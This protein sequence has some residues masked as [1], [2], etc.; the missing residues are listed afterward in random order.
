MRAGEPIY[1]GCMGGKGRTGLFWPY[2]RRRS[3]WLSPWSSLATYYAHA[4]ETKDQHEFVAVSGDAPAAAEDRWSGGGR[5]CVLE[6]E[7]DPSRQWSLKSGG[8][9]TGPF[10]KRLDP[11]QT[12]SAGISQASEHHKAR[13]EEHTGAL[14][15][16]PDPL[17]D[18]ADLPTEVFSKSTL[19]YRKNRTDQ[20]Q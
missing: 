20:P 2:W 4:V 10:D 18:L 12:R 9:Q 6:D 15:R 11:C 13:P 3:G 14:E 19:E 1:V 8:W 17:H 16:S 5:G 7:P